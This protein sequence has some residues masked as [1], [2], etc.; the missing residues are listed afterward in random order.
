MVRPPKLRPLADPPREEE[1]VAES[2]E[3][4]IDFDEPVLG[5]DFAAG[6]TCDV[7]TVDDVCAYYPEEDIS[8]DIA[9][10]GITL[11]SGRATVRYMPVAA[12][13]DQGPGSWRASLTIKEARFVEQ[14][15]VDLN[16]TQAII[17]AGYGVRRDTANRV[18]YQNLRRPRVAKAISMALAERSGVTVARVIDEYAKIGFSRITDYVSFGP[19]GVVLKDS[20]ALLAEGHDL[21]AISEV[22]QTKDGTKLKVHDKPAALAALAKLLGM[23]TDRHEIT[24]AGGEPLV[25]DAST[26][27]LARAVLSILS[28]A[29]MKDGE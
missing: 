3:V 18:A 6:S 9:A 28:T 7:R 19:D 23:T 15:L 2:A 27:D 4:R 26:R 13:S 8:V 5:I 20:A 11:W 24:G 17:R 1:F 12:S 25:P 14:Y 22:S 16:G 21:A 10:T 29:Q